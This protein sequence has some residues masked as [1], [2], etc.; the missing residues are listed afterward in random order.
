[1]GWD[2]SNWHKAGFEV[3]VAADK[4]INYQQNLIAVVVLGIPQRP[5]VRLYSARIAE[6]VN[7]AAPGSYVEV[8]VQ[9]SFDPP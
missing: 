1:L 5:L 6:A 4:N 9:A 2:G 7:A 3:F 8:Q